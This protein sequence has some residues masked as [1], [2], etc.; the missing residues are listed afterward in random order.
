MKKFGWLKW[1]VLLIC[2]FVV[3]FLFVRWY[4]NREEESKETGFV[5]KPS[6]EHVAMC[7]LVVSN[8]AQN[9]RNSDYWVSS[10]YVVYYDKTIY[11]KKIYN[12]SG[13]VVETE[14]PISADDY[15]TI[16]AF[17]KSSY[18]KTE[19]NMT[20][21]LDDEISYCFRFYNADGSTGNTFGNNHGIDELDAIYEMILSYTPEYEEPPLYPEEA[22]PD[23]A[24][25][26]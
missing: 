25:G 13:Y 1:A 16:C 15:Q 17:M 6:N 3:V 9:D 19:G 14:I 10:T 5:Y 8:S 2:L 22:T 7:S 26:E 23:N 11:I 12:L 18:M 21:N 20:T 24:A 4:V